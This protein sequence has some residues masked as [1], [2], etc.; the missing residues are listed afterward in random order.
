M[1]ITSL[2]LFKVAPRWLFLKT[3]TDEGICGWG[4][5]VIE[6]RA[7][8]VEAAVNEL[9]PISSDVI[10]S[11]SKIS[12]KPSTA[13]AFIAADRFFPVPFPV[14]NKPSGISKARR[15][16]SRFMNF[17]AAL[18]AIKSKFTARSAVTAPM[19]PPL[20]Q[21]KKPNRDTMRSK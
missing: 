4:E 3:M 12:S 9:A 21:P 15:S 5:P 14:S 17:S 7:D 16:M 1:K 19:I 2:E 11:R 13:A 8:T 18:C 6:G 10:R 20:R